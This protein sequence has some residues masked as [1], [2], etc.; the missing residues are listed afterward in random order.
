MD[1]VVI[2][3]AGRTDAPLV[4]ALAIQAARA[5]GIVPEP[6]F[7]DRYARAWLASRDHH[8]AWWA[9]AGGQHAGLLVATRTFALPWPERPPGGSLRVER[10]FVRDDQPVDAI[11]TALHAAAR[12]WAAARGIRDIQLG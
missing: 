3:Q 1:G 2:R 10:V 4:A 5:D 6:G 7:F 9:E 12:E 8:P 11:T